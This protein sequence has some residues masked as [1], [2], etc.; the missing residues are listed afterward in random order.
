MAKFEARRVGKA[1]WP[2]AV[3]VG[4][5]LVFLLGS[6]LV[7]SAMKLDKP[8]RRTQDYAHLVALGG[9]S[10]MLAKDI[11]PDISRSV[12]VTDLALM[13]DAGSDWVF[14]KLKPIAAGKLRGRLGEGQRGAAQEMARRL[15]LGAGGGRVEQPAGAPVMSGMVI[16]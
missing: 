12:L 13:A 6:R 5:L 10:F 3:G 7:D 9:S 4:G 1:L 14:A 11:A 2:S 15:A 8:F 16:G